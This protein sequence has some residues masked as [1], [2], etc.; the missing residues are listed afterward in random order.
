V[1]VASG[2]SIGGSGGTITF[3][4][5]GTLQLDASTTF[6]GA[7]SGFAVP[8]HLDL[9]D[10]A[11][12]LGTSNATFTEAAG[13]TSGTL[14]ISSGIHAAH[15]TLLGTY[16]TSQFHLGSDGHGGTLVTDPPVVAGGSSQTTF[17][18]FAPAGL[19]SGA[20]NPSNCSVAVSGTTN[21]SYG[22]G[23]QTLLPAGDPGGGSSLPFGW[24]R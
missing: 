22:A 16:V 9:R 3:A 21:L 15:L 23:G 7:I 13:N 2:G 24:H 11:F 18:D 8:D 12:V 19:L 5:G 17:D 6:T 1:E 20:G 14:T 4:N 10:I